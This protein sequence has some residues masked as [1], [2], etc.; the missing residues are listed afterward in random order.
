MPPKSK[1][2]AE[3][4]A[5]ANAKSRSRSRSKSETR[6]R[7]KAKRGSTGDKDEEMAER[8]PLPERTAF[9]IEYPGFVNN[10]DKAIL[11]LGGSERVSRHATSGIDERGPVQ[12]RFRYNDPVSHP[13]NGQKFATD[14]LLVKVT[15]RTRRL[16]S[17]TGEVVGPAELVSENA[18]VVAVI[19]KTAR[20][21]KLADFQFIVPKGDPLIQIAKALSNIDIDEAKRL[22]DSGVLD[23]GL[24]AST[25]YI[26]APFLDTSGWP[27]Q[28]PLKEFAEVP[29]AAAENKEDAGEKKPEK[30]KQKSLFHGII[31]KYDDGTVPTEPTPKA[32]EAV[33][34]VPRSLLRKAQD[35]LAQTPVISRNAMEVLIPPSERQGCKLVAIMHSMAYLMHPGTWRS[36]WIKFGYDPRK[37]E[38][39]YQYQVLD[40]RRK[41]TKEN[42][43]RIRISR[44]GG[45]A[46]ITKQPAPAKEDTAPK[47]TVEAQRYIFD[48][49]AASQDIGGIIQLLH[50]EI[51]VIRDL[52]NYS[53][54]RRRRPC[55][56]SGWLQPSLVKL[57]QAKLRESKRIYSEG[58][59]EKPDSLDVNYDE[60]NKAIAA[61]RK[62]EAAE[63][64]IEDM[65]RE[66]EVGPVLGQADRR[67]ANID[68]LMH[69]LGTLENR[70]VD[71]DAYDDG[72]DFDDFD[73]YG[74]ES[75]AESQSDAA[76]D[77]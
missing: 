58:S 39:A 33:K 77:D 75:D 9:S 63:L 55:Y 29:K 28:Y 36:C 69:N 72:A 35:I 45:G 38:G 15:K 8:K 21:R 24:D 71:D 7:S 54:G 73:I 51:P 60:L 43:G 68:K 57:I 22:C 26:P 64:E 14:N 59:N 34:H 13:I 23:S 20:F 10:T 76:D 52:V 11:T 42:A 17:A 74:E 70:E 25:G 1:T 41:A 56:E 3:P 27:S 66:R 48:E 62:K 67:E 53:S 6:S 46:N 37:D 16:K 50:I 44:R 49:T 30:S 2:K 31:V 4:K 18:E 5:K 19:D 47:N 40:M 12:L 32:L 61:D 65:L